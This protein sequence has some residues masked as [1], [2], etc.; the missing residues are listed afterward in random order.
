VYIISF[1]SKTTIPDIWS[2]HLMWTTHIDYGVQRSSILDNKIAIIL[3][4]K[5]AKGF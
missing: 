2:D 1:S 4:N 3:D 5:I